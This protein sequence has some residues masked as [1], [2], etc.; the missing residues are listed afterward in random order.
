VINFKAFAFQD[1]LM[2]EWQRRLVDMTG[3]TTLRSAHV[4][5]GELDEAFERLSAENLT[6]LS[7]KYGFTHVLR[8]TRLVEADKQFRVWTEAADFGRDAPGSVRF[9]VYR[10]APHETPTR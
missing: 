4:P 7:D 2:L 10:R 1:D 3:N 8:S 9:F 5:S 6:L